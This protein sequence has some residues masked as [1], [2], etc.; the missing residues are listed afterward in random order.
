MTT[1]VTAPAFLNNPAAK[2]PEFDRADVLWNKLQYTRPTKGNYFVRPVRVLSDIAVA[3]S[4][5]T[6]LAKA[7]EEFERLGS[8]TSATILPHTWGLIER[9]PLRIKLDTS[10]AMLHTHPELPDG[11]LLAAKV[12]TIQE[13]SPLND[14]DFTLIYEGFGR[15]RNQYLPGY[16]QNQVLT[17]VYSSVQYSKG[18]LSSQPKEQVILHDIEPLIA[19]K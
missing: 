12:E 7:D 11:V 5:D 17:D 4:L 3:F 19:L 14:D 18:Q 1:S 6:I 10:F 8:L 2:L 15:Y 16:N 13:Q 9:P